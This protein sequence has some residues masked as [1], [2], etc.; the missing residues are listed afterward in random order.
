MEWS[1]L[2]SARRLYQNLDQ[3][4]DNNPIRSHFDADY[5]R[6]IFSAPFRNLQDKTQVIPLPEDAFVH[7][8]LTHSLEVAS[9]GRSLGREVG[10]QII[11]KYPSLKK[12]HISGA[13][14]GSIVA[15]ACLAH[16]I[17][18]PSF[19]HS[20]E[21]AM[22]NFF[23]LHPE[24]K[25]EFKLTDLEWND[26]INF[27]GNANGFLALINGAGAIDHGIRLT[28]ATLGAFLKYPKASIKLKER[29][30]INEKKYGYFQ[31]DKEA[32]EKLMHNLNISF[33]TKE[34][35]KIYHRHPL[36]FLT[37]AADDICYSII[38]FED[39][40][41]LGWIDFEE[42]VTILKEI[43]GERLYE[44]RFNE[45]PSKEEQIGYL[46][47]N[48]IGLLI[49]DITSIFIKNESELLNG[50]FSKSLFD[51]SKYTSGLKK[52]KQLSIQKVYKHKSV[53]ELEAAG[54][55]IIENLLEKF[56]TAILNQ[57]RGKLDYQSGK[58]L[59]LLPQK[60]H[61]KEASAYL[62]MIRICEY[63]S[64]LTD[65]MAFNL[66]QKLNGIKI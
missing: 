41:R 22:S 34:N 52:I 36:V 25:E 21:K 16:D 32:F 7:N 44:K 66:Y 1:T 45:I 5:D 61:C 59:E 4:I 28:E 39:G 60:F 51:C 64:S 42:G 58:M 43:I 63:I 47:A 56:I 40:L 37:E 23:L 14:F 15:S 19:G 48:I 17:G 65:R 38:D 11:Q 62:Q 24:I 53:I 54:F 9:V 27:E 55:T 50:T 6:I 57:K 31:A 20:G 8:R 2:L 3:K 10:Y 13:D 49:E 33:Y 29:D 26:L 46:R 30:S 35:Q 12:Q 18:N